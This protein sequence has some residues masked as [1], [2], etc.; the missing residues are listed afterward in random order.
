MFNH[1][2]T[3][4]QHNWIGRKSIPPVQCPA[5][6]SPY[7]MRPRRA[8]PPLVQSADLHSGILC[9][10]HNPRCLRLKLCICRAFKS[11]EITEPSADAVN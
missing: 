8:S 9:P 6:H 10:N 2:C 4:C 7:W 1:Q 3:R 5:C 11:P